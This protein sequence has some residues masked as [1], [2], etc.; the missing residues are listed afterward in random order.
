[1]IS[2]KTSIMASRPPTANEFRL[3]FAQFATGVT[4]VTAER[5]PGLV[6]G[7][8]AN[9]LTSVSLDPLLLLICVAEQA[10]LLPLVRTKKRFGIN[11][12]KENQLAVSK[13]FAQTEEN[14]AAEANLGIRFRWT[15]SGIPLL[16]DSLVH[17]GCHVVASY[18]AGDH[19]IFIAEVESVELFDGEPL[20][21]FRGGYRTVA[22]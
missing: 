2:S 12:L 19:T 8:T 9:S 5:A 4:V 6:H 1:M 3:A 11:I 21:Y 13:Y 16:E 10:H 18:I 20:L 15:P 14:A 22:P 17:L 7:M